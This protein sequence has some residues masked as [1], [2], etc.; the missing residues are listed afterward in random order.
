MKNI[1]WFAIL[2]LLG[3]FLAGYVFGGLT[4]RADANHLCSLQMAE[5]KQDC[6]NRL[7]DAKFATAV[8]CMGLVDQLRKEHSK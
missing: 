6:V 4:H 3:V 7:A 1:P 5:M 2:V 8:K